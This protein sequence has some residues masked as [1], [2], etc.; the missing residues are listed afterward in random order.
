MTTTEHGAR[1][2]IWSISTTTCACGKTGYRCRRDARRAA[3]VLHPGEHLRAYTC[4]AA[5][6]GFGWHLG[7]PLLESA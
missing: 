5:L 4:D 1:D 6:P 7:H 3:R 2:R